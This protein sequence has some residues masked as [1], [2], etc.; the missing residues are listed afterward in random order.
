MS[1]PDLA[2]IAMTAVTLANT[3]AA[4]TGLRIVARQLRI[5]A[6]PK[7]AQASQAAAGGDR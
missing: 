1:T 3:A 7:E 4:L 2:I 5:A 6:P